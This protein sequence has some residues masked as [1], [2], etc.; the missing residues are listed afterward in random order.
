MMASAAVRSVLPGFSIEMTGKDVDA[1]REAAPALPAG[2][3]VNVTFLGNE[4]L[5]MRTAAARAAL[6]LGL[7]PVPHLSARRIGSR[8]ELDAILAE[9]GG[10]GASESVLVVGGDPAQPLGP[11][12]SSLE[13]VRT[14]A[15]ADAGVRE[16]W[17]AGYPEGHPDIPDDE[18]WRALEGKAAAAAEQGLGLG[19]I[20]QFGF[21]ADAVLDWL[22]AVRDRGI[23]A[24]V[25][26]GVPGP[27]G[28]KRLLAFA[29]RFGIASSASIVRKYGLS[30]ANLVGT[31]GPDRFLARLGEGLDPARHGEVGV[32][33]YP[34]GGIGATADWIRVAS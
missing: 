30:L 28:V 27:A 25:R 17:V 5:A 32:H 33:F 9:L 31:A 15:L 18:L 12:A 13:L 23:D 10:I 11:Y 2:T 3:R 8:A 19:V 22:A 6:E 7:H 4:D 29:G 16:L 24:P 26:V 1:L 21:D 34:F 20:T 14:G